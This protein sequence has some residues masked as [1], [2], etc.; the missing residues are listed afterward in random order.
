MGAD[1]WPAYRLLTASQRV[2]FG[3]VT[4]VRITVG[5]FDL[6]LAVAM[7]F[8]FLLLQGSQPIHHLW[9]QPKNLLVTAI[10]TAT[11]VVIRAFTDVVSARMAIQY[12]QDLYTDLLLQLMRG[13]NEMRWTNFIE[14][15]RS[16]LLNHTTYTAREAANFYLRSTELIAGQVVVAMM[17]ATVIYK[18]PLVASGIGL[19]MLL[20]YGTH[21][22]IIR[23][24]LHA[25]AAKREQ[26]V[27]VLQKVLAD[28]FASAK[29]VRVYGSHDFFQRRIRE[30][31]DSV[32]ASTVRLTS[33]PQLMRILSDQ[34]VLLAFLGMLIAVQMRQG[35]MRQL[36][37]VLLFY[38]VLSRRLLPLISQISF[39]AGQLDGSYE[40]IRLV[41]R[42]LNHCFEQRSLPLPSLVP[43]GDAVMEL[44]DVS[45]WFENDKP[46]LRNVSIRQRCGET[47]ILR[48]VSGSGK[49]SFLNLLAGILQPVNGL[50]CVDRAKIA[51]VPQETILLD[52]SVRT[53]L[54]FGLE[55]RSDEELMR[56]L[57]VAQLDTFV[58]SH[59]R[60]LETRVG[61]NGV[62][63]SGG[64]RQRLGIA[65]AL[66]RGATFLL[67]DEAT[68]AL[69]EQNELQILRSLATEGFAVLLVTHR[70][71]SR[72]V[73]NR[74]FRLE[75]CQLIED[76][77]EKAPIFEQTLGPVF[78]GV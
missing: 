55:Q 36:L 47:I 61:D 38:F 74:T 78:S 60:G 58:A 4:I 22:L 21:R 6:L 25:T 50:V 53:N 37:S 51:Y 7:Y 30:Q 34:G 65:R 14:T 44:R 23:N 1:Y 40:N 69:D 2:R 13:Y 39:L 66:L 57:R 46:I 8:V 31:A 33:L 68:S 19:A 17:A 54:L 45:F 52:E 48:G 72:V 27:S 32:G 49:S 67:L 15:N 73:A 70:M 71:N 16:E 12:G 11:L 26:A 64:Q 18:S 35:D 24:R 29:E 28:M 3:V 5:F 56:A 41:I 59:P 75:G 42:E 20:F 10:I 63:F 43:S 76:V 77:N 62:L 9:W